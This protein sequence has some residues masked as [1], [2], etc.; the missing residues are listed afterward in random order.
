MHA[1]LLITCGAALCEWVKLQMVLAT[2][3]LLGGFPFV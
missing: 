3:Q 2:G 1:T